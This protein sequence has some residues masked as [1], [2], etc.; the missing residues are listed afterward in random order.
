MIAFGAR[1]AAAQVVEVRNAAGPVAITGPWLVEEGESGI[2]NPRELAGFPKASGTKLPAVFWLR[3]TIRLDEPPA[4]PALLVSPIADS[5]A[6]FVNGVQAAQCRGLLGLNG[7][8][9]RGVLVPLPNIAAGQPISIAIRLLRP[10]VVASGNVGLGLG[11]VLLANEHTLAEIRTARDAER[12]FGL[13]PQTL[14]C[15]GELLG[16]T[17]LLVLFAY[18]RRRREYLWFALFLWLDGPCSLESVFERVYPLFPVGG[19]VWFDLFGLIARYAPLIGFLAAFTN[20]RVNRWIRGY[21]WVLVTLPLILG[22][23]TLEQHQNSWS[24]VSSWIVGSLLW[25]QLPF[26]IGS[27]LFL[28]WQWRK[29]NTEAAL[30][31]PSFLLANGVEMLGLTVP[32][33]GRHISFGRFGWDFDDLSMF[34]FLV[35]IAPVMIVRHW[36]ITKEHARATAELD[37]AR[38][39]QQRLVPTRLPEIAGCRIEAAYMPA[40]EV[41]G[42]FYQV[43]PRADGSTLIAVGDVSGKG[44]KAA[45][46]GALAIG[47]LRTLAA[48]SLGPAAVLTRLN[49]EL[50]RAQNGGFVTCFCAVIAPDS[51][52]R[53]A[54]AGHLAPY[55]N[56]TEVEA[57]GALPL[58]L[59]P[60]VLYAEQT[61]RL[62]PGDRLTLL[63]DGVVEAQNASGELFGF[64]RTRGMSRQTAQAIAERARSFGQADDITVV[65]LE[66]AAFA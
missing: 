30:L 61:L 31:I 4:S 34:F 32:G 20:V 9:H 29:G 1:C 25:A 39:I 15:I 13:L 53:F 28:F 24:A 11:D 16:G 55:R 66:R 63:S 22:M 7:L 60:D 59:S 41:G 57:P 37:A 58:G 54:N 52:L 40:D 47:A 51:M 12:F 46:T 64:E 10:R 27:L 19:A 45:M 5:C 8:A 36:R 3:T 42:D 6:V 18:D 48:E 44:L 50:V 14:L 23:V 65:T 35:S 62:E 2:G 43:L 49:E 26:V 17:V 33:W 21:Q 38:E 56:G